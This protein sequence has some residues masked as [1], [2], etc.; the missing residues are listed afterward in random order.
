MSI[1]IITSN[2]INGHNDIK[3]ADD[4]NQT[5]IEKLGPLKISR[6]SGAI[7]SQLNNAYGKQEESSVLEKTSPQTRKNR[8]ESASEL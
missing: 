2:A 6:Q 4:G 7:C 1:A 8:S 5:H 3:H